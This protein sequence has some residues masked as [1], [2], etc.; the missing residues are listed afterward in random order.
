[1]KTFAITVSGKVQGVYFRQSTLEKARALG[2]TGTVQNRK[3]G[4]VFIIASGDEQMLENM[5]EWCKRGPARAVV[6]NV[7]VAQREAQL[8]E[9]FRIIR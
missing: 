5:V 7:E 8:F 6:T 3:D 1:M 4:S 9:G 2:I